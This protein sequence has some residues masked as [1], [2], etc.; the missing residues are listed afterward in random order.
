MEKINKKKDCCKWPK[1]SPTTLFFPI[2]GRV[3]P[4][5]FLHFIF[6]AVLHRTDLETFLK[7]VTHDNRLCVLSWKIFNMAKKRNVLWFLRLPGTI[8]SKFDL[9]EFFTCRRTKITGCNKKTHW[10]FTE[11][12]HSFYLYFRINE[13]PILIYHSVYTIKQECLFKRWWKLNPSQY[14][15]LYKKMLANETTI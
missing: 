12:R 7:S 14:E 9:L 4:K 1:K 5:M 3:L 11:K 13:I 8:P 2:F 6:S 15:T 10:F